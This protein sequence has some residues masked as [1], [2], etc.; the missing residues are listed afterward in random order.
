MR[1]RLITSLCVCAALLMAVGASAASAESSQIANSGAAPASSGQ[2][3]TPRYT[4]IPLRG[5][6]PAAI[7][8]QVAAATTVGTWASSITSPTDHHT[9]SYRMVGNSPLVHEASPISKVPTDVIPVAFHFA[10]S[11]ITFDPTAPSPGCLNGPGTA[12]SLFLGSP[13]VGNHAYVVGGT[14]VGNTQYLDAFQRENF[15]KYDINTGAINPG[16]HVLLSPVVNRAKVSITVTGGGTNFMG[17][18]GAIG[19]LDIGSWD[20]YVQ[21]TLLPQLVAAKLTSPTHFPFFL[22]YNV[23]LTQGGGCCIIGYHSA[24][25]PTASSPIQTYGNGDYVEPGLFTGLN[26]GAALTHEVGE[27]MDDPYGNNAT[28]AWGH[29]GQVSGCQGNLEVGDPLS[30]TQIGVRMGNNV[31]YHAQEL[32]FRDWFYRTPSVGL[33]GWFSSNGKF[34]TSAGVLCH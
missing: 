13:V 32:A 6:S 29:I 10:D 33:H 15:A 12:D 16:Y 3:G 24:Y 30:G 11:G 17:C 14:T 1:T 26:D 4:V 27:W 7:G 31:V 8:K 20:S 28:P 23:V 25:Q 9:Y 21:S 34:K 18:T 2:I 5:V 19:E 22:F